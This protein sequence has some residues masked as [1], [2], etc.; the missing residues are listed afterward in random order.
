M[1]VDCKQIIICKDVDMPC[2]MNYHSIN[3]DRL[4]KI[5]QNISQEQHIMLC[6]P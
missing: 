2:S 1:I 6:H 3:L 4:K 5:M